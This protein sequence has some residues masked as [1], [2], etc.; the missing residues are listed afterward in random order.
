MKFIFASLMVGVSVLAIP[1]A[2]QAQANHVGYLRNFT[3]ALD[4]TD[5]PPLFAY[6]SWSSSEPINFP[7]VGTLTISGQT[8]TQAL[9]QD[10]EVRVDGRLL[11][12]NLNN[13][14][15]SNGGDTLTIFFGTEGGYVRGSVSFDT[16]SDLIDSFYYSYYNQTYNYENYGDY[17]FSQPQAI[18]N[19]GSYNLSNGGTLIIGAVPEPSTWLMMIVGFGGIGYSIRRR[20]KAA[21]VM[22]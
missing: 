14:R 11:D 10:F 20:R 8:D 17:S 13:F 3:F 6:E 15:F 4:Y 18:F 21:A 16:P 22:A 12:S 7:D 9:H 5:G 1:S 19:I 2:A